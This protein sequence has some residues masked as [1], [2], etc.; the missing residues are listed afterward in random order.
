MSTAGRGWG[1]TAAGQRAGRAF[2]AGLGHRALGSGRGGAAAWRSGAAGSAC[3]AAAAP[4]TAQQVALQVQLVQLGQRGLVA[5]PGRQQPGER[6]VGEVQ[7]QQRGVGQ[8]RGQLPR[9]PIVAQQNVVARHQRKLLAHGACMRG[10]GG[11]GWGA[12]ACQQDSCR[13]RRALLSHTRLRTQRTRQLVGPQVQVH[14]GVEGGRVQPRGRQ[15]AGK[16]VAAEVEHRHEQQPRQLGRQGARQPQP[17]QRQRRHVA[18]AVARQAL[19]R[20][21]RP[22]RLV[23]VDPR[24]PRYAR[25]CSIPVA[26]RGRQGQQRLRLGAGRPAVCGEG[27]RCGVGHVESGGSGRRRRRRRPLLHRGWAVRQ[28]C[29]ATNVVVRAQAQRLGPAGLQTRQTARGAS[30]GEQQSRRSPACT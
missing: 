10:G 30:A 21:G 5:P 19:P 2:R 4:R 24:C 29:R 26:Y 8:R 23:T 22:A 1:L 17:W 15:R 18:L 27:Q 9:Q 7:V 12:R 16:H 3:A 11:R 28:L 20:R 14:Q 6:V 13:R 25:H